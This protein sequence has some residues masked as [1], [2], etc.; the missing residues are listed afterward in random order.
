MTPDANVLIA[1]TRADHPHHMAARRWLESAL[2]QATPPLPLTLLPVVVVAFARVVT[3]ARVF[4]PPTPTP[5][6]FAFVAG[7]LAQPHVRLATHGHEVPRLVEL[8]DRHS[9]AGNLLTDAWIAASV[10]HLGEH[11][12]TFDRDFLRLLPPRHLTLLAA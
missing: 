10:L 5:E 9:L 8:C 7:L 11:L 4:S 3:N 2:G 1:A 6:A 12:V